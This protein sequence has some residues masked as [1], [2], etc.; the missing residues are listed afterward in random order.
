MLFMHPEIYSEAISDEQG[1]V[2]IIVKAYQRGQL[3]VKSMKT[4]VLIFTSNQKM[5]T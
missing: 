4:E 1:H 5:Q 3:Y 2:V